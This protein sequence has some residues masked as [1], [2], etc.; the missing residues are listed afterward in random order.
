MLFSAMQR[1]FAPSQL[2]KALLSSYGFEGYFT[3]LLC[4]LIVSYAFC[5]ITRDHLGNPFNIPQFDLALVKA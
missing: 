1:S 3:L 2:N 4:Q 5:V